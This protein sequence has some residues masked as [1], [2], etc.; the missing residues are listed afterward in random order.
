V[1]FQVESPKKAPVPTPRTSPV[2]VT[3][4]VIPEKKSEERAPTPPPIFDE[5]QCFQRKSPEPRK[6]SSPTNVESPVSP[7]KEVTSQASPSKSQEV[8]VTPEDVKIEFD[9]KKVE[10]VRTSAKYEVQMQQVK[11]GN[12]TNTK[13]DGSQDM[14]S[15]LKTLKESGY[16]ATVTT[17]RST[18]A[19]KTLIVDDGQNA[20]VVSEKQLTSH[21]IIQDGE[22]VSSEVN[23]SEASTAQNT[24][25][26]S[27]PEVEM[28]FQ[29]VSP[30]PKEEKIVVTRSTIKADEPVAVTNGSPSEIPSPVKG[31]H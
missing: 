31:Q 16:S 15:I 2:K 18:M 21:E 19:K 8:K 30:K 26:L 14:E 28:K 1:C 20:P 24:L 29:K 27:I 6:P 4:P 12:L 3:P 22:V 10:N 23:E 9:Q 17:S 13:T 7:S 5:S 11:S 25:Q